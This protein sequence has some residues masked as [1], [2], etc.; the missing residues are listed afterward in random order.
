[1]TTS[2]GIFLESHGDVDTLWE[3]C[4]EPYGRHRGLELR[5]GDAT[6]DHILVVGLPYTP[7]PRPKLPAGE[8]L[9]AAV[10]GDSGYRK[11]VAAWDRLGVPRERTSVLFYEPTPYVKDDY[12]DVARRF[13]QRVYGTDDRADKPVTL[14][15]MWLVEGQLHELRGAQPVEKTIPLAVVSSGKNFLPG[16]GPRLGFFEKLH[17]AGVPLQA[18]GRGLPPAV[19]GRGSVRY[20]RGVLDAARFALA[21]ENHVESPYYITEKLWDALLCWCLPFYFGHAS[22]DDLVP[23]EC[24]IRLPDLGDAGVEVVR[25]A[26]ANPGL[27]DERR[28]AIAEARHRIL[29]DLRMVEWI[30]REIVGA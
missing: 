4:D 2:V 25:E 24:Y 19:R 14:G 15:S 16:H 29:G 9:R 8:R 26:L 11:L 13:A 17:A 22:V 6:A 18:F 1:M 21:L 30:R 23:A 20:K 12:Y 5:G 28:D 3:Q 27:W 10:R 7:G